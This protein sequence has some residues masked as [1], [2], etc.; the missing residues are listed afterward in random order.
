MRSEEREGGGEGGGGG[1]DLP[2]WRATKAARSPATRSRSRSGGAA[3]KKDSATS[4]SGLRPA[5][6]PPPVVGSAAMAGGERATGLQVDEDSVEQIKMRTS[7]FKRSEEIGK[8]K[9]ENT[10]R[11]FDHEDIRKFCKTIDLKTS[12]LE[13]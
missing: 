9:S 6:P 12:D 11:I 4:S 13:E 3:R 1:R 2:A 7:K 5:A 10:N 8:K